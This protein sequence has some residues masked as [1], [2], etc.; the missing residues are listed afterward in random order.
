VRGI[1]ADCP[2]ADDLELIACEMV[3]NTIRHTPAGEP[4]GAFTLTVRT[5]TGW[6]RI[7]VSGPSSG[8]W[9]HD[10]ATAASTVNTGV[11]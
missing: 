11:G 6:A 2:R 7:E 5:S 1:V 4:G 3:S 10:R 9:C 8:E